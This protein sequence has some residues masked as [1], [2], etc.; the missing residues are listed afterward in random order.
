MR[1]KERYEYSCST[2]TDDGRVGE[3]VD[4]ESWEAA[5]EWCDGYRDGGMIRRS[6][7]LPDGKWQHQYSWTGTWH[8][9]PGEAY[10]IACATAR[11]ASLTA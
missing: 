10:R 4:V 9:S 5:L 3:F 1:T 8:D 7:R 6:R 2:V 11:Y